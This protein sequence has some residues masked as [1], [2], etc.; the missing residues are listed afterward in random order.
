MSVQ[1]KA[2]K[3]ERAAATSI[4]ALCWLFFISGTVERRWFGDALDRAIVIEPEERPLAARVIAVAAENSSGSGY[5]V[6]YGW[7]VTHPNYGVE[8]AGETA[9]SFDVAEAGVYALWIRVRWSG[10]CAN[11]VTV[12][13][14]ERGGGDVSRHLV[15]NDPVFKKWHWIP[16]FPV[17]LEPGAHEILLGTREHGADVDCML[18][19]QDPDYIPVGPA[20]RATADAER[21]RPS[22]FDFFES[23]ANESAAEAPA[24]SKW[25]NDG[26]AW[27][28]EVRGE[29]HAAGPRDIGVAMLEAVTPSFENAFIEGA[30]GRVGTT[31]AGFFFGKGDGPERFLVRVVSAPSRGSR[32]LEL[33]NVSGAGEVVLAKADV[34]AAQGQWTLLQLWTVNS[35]CHAYLD[36]RHVLATALPRPPF[37]RS[38]L[39]VGEGHADDDAPAARPLFGDFRV[40]NVPART[41]KGPSQRGILPR[42]VAGGEVVHPLYTPD[43]PGSSADAV[44]LTVPI[45]LDS[46]PFGLEF[47][48]RPGGRSQ[49]LVFRRTGDGVLKARLRGTSQPPVLFRDPPL[50]PLIHLVFH[51][52]DFSAYVGHTLLFSALRTDLRAP[53]VEYRSAASEPPPPWIAVTDATMLESGS[54]QSF[55]NDRLFPNVFDTEYFGN[56]QVVIPIDPTVEGVQEITTTAHDEL[57]TAT[58]S[59]LRIETGAA[60]TF[61]L[62]ENDQVTE[63]GPL[64]IQ[65]G[66]PIT[67]CL[68]H[69]GPRLTTTI[70]GLENSLTFSGWNPDG[71]RR[72]VAW[73]SSEVAGLDPVTGF[74]WRRWDVHSTFHRESAGASSLATWKTVRGTWDL[75]PASRYLTTLVGRPDASGSAEIRYAGELESEE[76]SVDVRM[77]P[78]DFPIGTSIFV[79]LRGDRS[80]GVAEEIEFTRMQSG[81]VRCTIRA[82]T[83]MTKTSERLIFLTRHFML[84]A[85][86]SRNTLRA[87]VND[88]PLASVDVAG[89]GPISTI[90]LGVRH[91]PEQTTG[92]EMIGLRLSPHMPV[93][94]TQRWRNFV[95]LLDDSLRPSQ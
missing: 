24:M 20:D 89:A 16:A 50:D 73:S 11:S 8:V 72:R 77:N 69:S 83:S 1:V 65:V 5:V 74:V 28:T 32:R 38:G 13:T 25:R 39:Y 79:T 14:R 92:I 2:L 35:F 10:V 37:G 61:A 46:V 88:V 71:P 67:V 40:R 51:G 34:D 17:E 63:S 86:R 60:P 62:Y 58:S 19:V 30:L 9:Y 7:D 36:G 81:E 66:S 56:A 43:E 47:R 23:F 52:R 53:R 12:A 41:L 26:S 33:V 31:P 6:I 94:A 44:V 27:I 75:E 95:R 54:W 93:L 78:M 90:S 70:A 57:P 21:V 55:P 85:H 82:T 91:P 64:D 87:L 76:L 22:A 3:L 68:S 45:D 49:S 42:E 18:L 84:S 4:G 15:G 29:V 48:L 80:S 59:R